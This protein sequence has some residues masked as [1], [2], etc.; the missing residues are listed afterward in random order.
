MNQALAGSGHAPADASLDAATLAVRLEALEARV[1]PEIRL[2]SRYSL[3]RHTTFQIGG[4][5]D[6]YFEPPTVEALAAVLAAASE[7][8][9]PVTCLGGGSNVLVSDAGVRGLV[10][11]LGKAFAYI[12]ETGDDDTGVSFEVG[13]A[14]APRDFPF[15]GSRPSSNPS[16]TPLAILIA[17]V[18]LR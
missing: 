5:A 7:I 18:R 15:M 11:R 2:V 14:C 9:V 1:G 12:R 10:I 6:L 13:A 16:N 4:E 17:I 8:G 3:G